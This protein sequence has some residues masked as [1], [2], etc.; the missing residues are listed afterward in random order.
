MKMKILYGT[1]NQGKLLAMKKSVD[2]LDIEL[3][4]LH[5]VEGIFD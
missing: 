1:T 5:D 4:S 3:I 2:G